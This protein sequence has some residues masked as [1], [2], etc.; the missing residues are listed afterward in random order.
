MSEIITE[1]GEVVSTALAMPDTATISALARAEIDSQIATARTYPRDVKRAMANIMT[2][3]TLDEQ[4][5]EEAIYS[6]PRGGK[7]VEGA[8]VRLAETVSQCW[9]NCRVEARVVQVDR[10]EKVVVAEGIFH[11]LETNMATRATVRRRIVDSKGRLYNDDMITVTGNAACSIAKRN[12]ILAGTPR[13]IW[14]KAYEQARHMIAGDT[15]TLTVTREKAIKALAHYGLTPEQ[16]FALIGVENA[17]QITTDHVVSL[18]GTFSALKNAETT[19]EELLRTAKGTQGTAHEK[20]VDP[21]ANVP[22]DSAQKQPDSGKSE[23]EGDKAGAGDN[24]QPTTTTQ[25]SAEAGKGEPDTKQP[26]PPKELTEEEL[27]AFWEK[28][29]KRGKAGGS[30]SIPKE[31]QRAEMKAA[32]SKYLDGYDTAR[33]EADGGDNG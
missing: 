24:S 16:I 17:E 10:I 4:T 28:G 1:D 22:R 23:E 5:A 3:T 19:V 21:L 27:Q 14:R 9:G 12:A 30:R 29:H 31:L 8:S 2:L 13:G 18:R 25:A 7:P 20:V 33:A 6:L 15:K 26:E 32:A 11:D